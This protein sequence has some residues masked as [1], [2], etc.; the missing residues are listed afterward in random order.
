MYC[1]VIVDI[2][3]E[4]VASP[5]TYRIPDMMNLEPGQRVAV[6][7]GHREK[8]GIVLEL[9]ED[10]DLDPARI[11]D[12]LRTLEDYAAI[13]PEL[14]ALAGEMAENAHC[15]LAETLRLM[16]PAQMRGGRIHIRTERTAKLTVTPDEA[17]TA[18]EAET[19]SRKRAE[20]LRVLSE[21]EE[22]SIRSLSG[23]VKDPAEAL[24]KL[25][26][27]GLIE[28]R[29]TETLRTPAELFKTKCEQQF[30]LTPGQEEALEEILPALQGD[31]GRFLL[32]GVTGSGKT[33]VF[34]EA[35]RKVLELGRSAIIL[36]PEIALTPQLVAWFRRR[37]GPV[38]A[39]IH[40]RLSAGERFD[41]W[42]RIRKRKRPRRNRCPERGFFAGKKPRTDRR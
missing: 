41:E 34:M 9:T 25:A 28:I 18:A 15:P 31:G 23:M 29:E 4:N 19:R 30:V 20:I 26:A 22:I 11:R 2:V 42:R 37:F 38:A 32:H 8:E 5:F 39:V 17:I 35:V 1:Q 10:C 14:M 16:L 33:E 27:D 40:S 21:T 12:V 36:V 6:P 3:H 13:P 24:K 7:F